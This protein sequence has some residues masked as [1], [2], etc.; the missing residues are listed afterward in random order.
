MS[1]LSGL[2]CARG[3]ESVWLWSLQKMVWSACFPGTCG[4][5]LC[6]A[7]LGGT[8]HGSDHLISLAFSLM[9]SKNASHSKT[10]H[11]TCMTVTTENSKGL[12]FS[13]QS[14]L[15]PCRELFAFQGLKATVKRLCIHSGDAHW[16]WDHEEGQMGVIS[17]NTTVTAIQSKFQIL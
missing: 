15:C 11:M 16:P 17:C 6:A 12:E 5:F 4:S 8:M 7:C 14:L 2:L 1:L 10:W 3:N 9:E 13:S